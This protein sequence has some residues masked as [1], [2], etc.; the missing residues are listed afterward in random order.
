MKKHILNH[1][2]ALH[3]SK[4]LGTM[5]TYFS[6]LKGFIA[7]GILY[8]PKNCKNG[9]WLFTIFTMVFSF[10]VTYFSI[11]KLLQAREKAPPGSSFADIANLAIGKKGKI[12]TD[13]FLTLLQYGFVISFT[14]FVLDSMK[15]VIDEIF[16]MD[17]NV[18]WIG[19]I[20]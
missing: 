10:F 1:E 7:I 8:M 14:Y 13:V 11:L 17:I 15:S 12:S 3:V 5:S 18:I 19:K 4:K 9:G 16:D 6:L 2:E 20:I